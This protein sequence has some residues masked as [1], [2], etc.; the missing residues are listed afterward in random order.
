MNPSPSNGEVQVQLKAPLRG[1]SVVQTALE[2][3]GLDRQ[4]SG[5]EKD[6]IK[7]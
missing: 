1:P 3:Q 2:S 5:T 7:Y 4:G 6:E